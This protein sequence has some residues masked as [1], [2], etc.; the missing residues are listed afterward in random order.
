[1]KRRALLIHVQRTLSRVDCDCSWRSVK[2]VGTF[3]TAVPAS[4]KRPRLRRMRPFVTAVALRTDADA[5][6]VAEPSIVSAESVC[7]S[8]RVS[9]STV[10]VGEP[11]TSC[12]SMKSLKGIAPQNVSA[13][14]FSMNACTNSISA[15]CA[16]RLGAF[17]TSPRKA[18]AAESRARWA[19]R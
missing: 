5:A 19:S 7:A 11:R 15:A 6:S 3:A 17:V 14:K 12:P 8:A 10:V 4:A 16:R 2:L 1:V 9:A 18:C 13:R